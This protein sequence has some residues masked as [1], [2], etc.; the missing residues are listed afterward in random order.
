MKNDR[1]QSIRYVLLVT[2]AL[3]VLVAGT[4]II[5]GW[6]IS[7]L[8]LAADG[9]HSLLDGTSNIV[10]L[11]AISY[12]ERPPDREHPY[13][14]RKFETLAAMGISLFLFLSGF[15]ILEHAVKRLHEPA[16]VNVGFWSLAALVATMVVNL[17]ITRYESRRGRELQSEFLLADSLHTRTDFYG[18]LLV[19]VSLILTKAGYPSFDSIGALLIVAILARAGYKVILDAFETLS[20]RA[21]ID[22]REI[23]R[24]VM[25]VENVRDCHKI[26][27]RGVGDAVYVD[28]HIWVD[29][30]ISTDLG[31][32]IQHTVMQRIQ[33]CF[34]Q[35][36][37][38]VVHLEPG[39]AAPD[40]RPSSRSRPPGSAG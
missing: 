1:K 25:D 16:D 2:L 20:D 8:S 35:V 34:P 12:A 33:K 24:C 30:S 37:D 9:I 10:G 27:S 26:R 32:S 5:V 40:V 4:K 19:L 31:H 22:P 3:N 36:T 15:Q 39:E 23:A 29:P 6:L 11:V 17:F 21:R 7:S 18:A 13:G 14:H 28:L 38:V